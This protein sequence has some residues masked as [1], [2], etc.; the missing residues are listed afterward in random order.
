MKEV[1]KVAL[2]CSICFVFMPS[3]SVSSDMRHGTAAPFIQGNIYIVPPVT[4][5]RGTKGVLVELHQ[6]GGTKMVTII[7]ARGKSF[8]VCLYHRL[9][10]EK[11]W[12]FYL[13]GCPGTRGSIRVINEEDFKPKIL[14]GV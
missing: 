13:D 7:D 2:I 10:R 3:C 4:L 11:E 8:D 14:N 9:G 12:G 5:K 6:D 1:I